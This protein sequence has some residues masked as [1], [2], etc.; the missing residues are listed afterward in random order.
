[1]HPKVSDPH[2]RKED[3]QNHLQR[4]VRYWPIYM[5]IFG[6]IAAGFTVQAETRSNA[7]AIDNIQGQMQQLEQSIDELKQQNAIMGERSKNTQTDVKDI[8]QDVKDI[9]KALRNNNN[10]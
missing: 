6:I 4:A 5:F 10:Q 3:N 1:M 9:L 2:R 7:K 8:K